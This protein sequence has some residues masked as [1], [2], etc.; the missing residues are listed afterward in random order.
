MFL[1]PGYLGCKCRYLLLLDK[2]SKS[3]S[4][5][6]KE[7]IETQ[8]WIVPWPE[9]HSTSTVG[10]KERQVFVASC[11]DKATSFLRFQVMVL[12]LWVAAS[13]PPLALWPGR[14]S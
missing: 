8:K 6:P 12:E 5:V 14:D 3:Q 1:K 10:Q 11:V 2:E 4:H 7:E 13:P 9:S